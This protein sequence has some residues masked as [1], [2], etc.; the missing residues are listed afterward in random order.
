MFPFDD[1]IK[2]QEGIVTT[3]LHTMCVIHYDLT[4]LKRFLHCWL[5]VGTIPTG[6]TTIK[7]KSEGKY[8]SI[9]KEMVWHL[10]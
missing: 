1:V 3:C 9:E 10:I 7:H 2:M 5:F 6:H 8:N 4:A